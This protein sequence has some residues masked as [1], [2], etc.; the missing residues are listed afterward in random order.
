MTPMPNNDPVA[1]FTIRPAAPG[2]AA[3][4]FDLIKQLAEYEKLSHMVVG[5]ETMLHDALFGKHPAGEVVLGMENGEPVGFALYYTTFS[6]F[7]CRA[8]IH[9]EDLFVL[10]AKRG[11]GYG[12]ALL[13]HLAHIAVQRNCGRLEWNVLDWNTP[14]LEFYDSIGGVHM[15]DW[16]LYRMTHDRFS[17]FANQ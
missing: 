17:A 11:Q 8:G 15:K 16:W 5:N 3:V 13:K 10:P 6:T 2:D 7:L 4:I 14:S 9:L 1:N 12:K